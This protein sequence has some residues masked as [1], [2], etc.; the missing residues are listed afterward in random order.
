VR[1][2]T[3]EEGGRNVEKQATQAQVRALLEGIE[4]LG[5]FTDELYTTSHTPC[6]QC[7]SVPI[8]PAGKSAEWT[9][10]VTVPN[11]VKGLYIMLSVESGKQRLFTNYCVDITD[12]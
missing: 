11:E 3:A 5:W 4:K 9:T 12:Q 2:I 8:T 7:Y 10:E 1:I 6:R